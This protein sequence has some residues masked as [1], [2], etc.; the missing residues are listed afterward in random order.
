[1]RSFIKIHFKEK[2]SLIY[3]KETKLGD[4]LS[5]IEDA[6]VSLHIVHKTD[7]EDKVILSV[8]DET[9]GC[10]LHAFKYFNFLEVND[11]I[12]LRSFKVYD[13]NVIEMN[14]YSNILKVPEYT[15]YYRDFMNRISMKMKAIEPTADVPM[16]ETTSDAKDSLIQCVA[17]EEIPTKKLKDIGDNKFILDVNIISIQPQ[18]ATECVLGYCNKCQER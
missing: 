4:R 9:D 1:L 13:K 18:E 7:M 8:Q 2:K 6:D 10:E 5:I 15:D 16:Y 3:E 14:K 12:R 17:A 11:V